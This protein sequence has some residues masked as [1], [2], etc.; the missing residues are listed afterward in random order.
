MQKALERNLTNE[1]VMLFSISL[2]YNIGKFIKDPN[3][4][5]IILKFI[6]LFSFFENHLEFIY[7]YISKHMFDIATNKSGCCAVQ[8]IIELSNQSNKTLLLNR[9]V[10][11]MIKLINEPQGNFV[12]G[13]VISLKNNKINK[14]I[15]LKIIDNNLL[16]MSTQ[17]F[18]SIMIEK[19]IE[20]GGIEIRS[21][22]ISKIFTEN[23]IEE[24]II[25]NNGC[26]SKL[27]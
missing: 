23:Y 26:S 19:L 10:K 17:K 7:S 11:L 1:Q 5:H 15:A 2:Q 18:S 25:D 14:E 4:Y 22:I 13:F 21:L 24:L 27:Y 20:S 8:K 6:N 16:Y 12:I 3:A 9:I